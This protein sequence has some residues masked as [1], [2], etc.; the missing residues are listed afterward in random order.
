MY[1]VYNFGKD[2]RHS[3]FHSQISKRP[4]KK[5]HK[6]DSRDA[7]NHSA[8]RANGTNQQVTLTSSKYNSTTTNMRLFEHA[9]SC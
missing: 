9:R 4:A 5:R 3:V 7:F 1:C 8:T 6:R 2:G